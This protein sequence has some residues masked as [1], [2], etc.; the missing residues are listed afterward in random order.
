[1][2]LRTTNTTPQSAYLPSGIAG[3]YPEDCICIAEQIANR[4]PSAKRAPTLMRTP[5]GARGGAFGATVRFTV[6][7]TKVACQEPVRHLS[8]SRDH[9]TF[10]E[11]FLY[12]PSR[13]R[14]GNGFPGFPIGAPAE[15]RDATH[16]GFGGG[17]KTRYRRHR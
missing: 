9:G 14:Q 8:N 5:W 4:F 13:H 7:A 10:F 11:I 15:E 2:L 6:V 1:M 17:A 12:K 16:G 3:G